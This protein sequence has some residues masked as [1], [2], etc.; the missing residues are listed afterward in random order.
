MA[1]SIQD[2]KSALKGGGARANLFSVSLTLPTGVADSNWNDGTFSILCKAAALPA[3]TV[4]SIDVPFRGR[5]FKVAGERTFEPWTITVINDED[6][7]IRRTMERWAQLVAQYGDGS[8]ATSPFSYMANAKVDQLKRGSSNLSASIGTG[9]NVAASY[10]FESIFP[11][12]ISAIDLSYD[13][14]DA[15]EEFTVEFQVQYWYPSTVSN[16][17]ATAPTRT[18]QSGNTGQNTTTG[19]GTG[20]QTA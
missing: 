15:I 14:S 18:N 17:V 13:T 10:N 3:S 6:F 8:G 19:T 4:A 2:F 16:T 20:S 12:S 5:I 11:T 1:H 7:A 9:L